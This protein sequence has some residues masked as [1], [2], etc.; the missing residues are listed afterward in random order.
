MDSKTA[1]LVAREI[2]AAFNETFPNSPV[3]RDVT[4]WNL[5]TEFKIKLQGRIAALAGP[6]KG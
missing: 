1:E 6:P 5:M 2:D 4:M 3:S